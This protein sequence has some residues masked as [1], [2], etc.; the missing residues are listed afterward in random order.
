[1][2]KFTEGEWWFAGGREI[3]SMPSQTKI[4]KVHA[5]HSLD[6]TKANGRLL[7][8]APQMLDMLESVAGLC[9]PV[10]DIHDEVVTLIKK[11]K[12]I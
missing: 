3:I 10:S 2:S 12:E 9:G 5:V 8:M 1:M 11:V 4:A 7:A 6:E